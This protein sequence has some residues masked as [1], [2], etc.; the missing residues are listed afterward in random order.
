M[1]M[2]KSW[3]MKKGQKVTEFCDQSWN[4]TPEFYQMNFMVFFADFQKYIISLES[5]HFLPFLQNVA[6][7]KFAQRSGHGKSRNSHR[8]VM[9]KKFAKSAGTLFNPCYNS[10]LL[11]QGFTVVGLGCT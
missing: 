4:F 7:A 2:D 11:L 10:G 8:K 3:N 6:H 1:V 9:D 5:K